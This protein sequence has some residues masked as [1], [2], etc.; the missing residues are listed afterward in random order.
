MTLNE[1]E[2]WLILGIFL[3]EVLSTWLL[4]QMWQE[5]RDNRKG[6]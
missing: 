5:S 3:M 4:W 2:V 1:R 6:D